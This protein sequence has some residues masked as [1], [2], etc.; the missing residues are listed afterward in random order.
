ME[1]TAPVPW[2]TSAVSQANSSVALMVEA[3]A[4]V[5]EATAPVLR[6]TLAVLRVNSLVVLMAEA[7]AAVEAEEAS[8]PV[9]ESLSG[10][11]LRAS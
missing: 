3:A 10:S 5:V 6:V 8:N 7:V 11:W 9:L 2:V 4:A 1:V